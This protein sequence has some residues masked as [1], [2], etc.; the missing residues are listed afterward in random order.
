VERL[1]GQTLPLVLER[2]SVFET[3]GY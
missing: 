3:Y 2:A 1:A